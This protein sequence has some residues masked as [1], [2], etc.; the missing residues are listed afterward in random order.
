ME[1]LVTDKEDT[2]EDINE[3][4]EELVNESE[5]GIVVARNI[6]LD[7]FLRYQQENSG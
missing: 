6:S 7:A 5:N 1:K 3:E 4:E 2:Q